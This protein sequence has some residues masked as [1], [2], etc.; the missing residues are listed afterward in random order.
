MRSGRSWRIYFYPKNCEI[1]CYRHG[2]DPPKRLESLGNSNK[3]I[4]RKYPAITGLL[5]TIRQHRSSNRF[6]K[7]QLGM[8]HLNTFNK[9][10]GESNE[11]DDT[12]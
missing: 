8:V 4:S 5:D 10:E 3:V 2:C 11:A 7:Y 6:Q 9:C 12:A 1:S